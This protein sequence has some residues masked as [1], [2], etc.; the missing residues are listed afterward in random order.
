LFTVMFG[1]AAAAS[2][3]A[4]LAAAAIGSAP[5]GTKPATPGNTPLPPAGMNI[6]PPPPPPAE[7]QRG[8]ALGLFAEDVS[9]SYNALLAEVV[10]LG[11][12]H[13]ALVVP[14]YQ[15]HGGSHD[16]ALHTRYSPTLAA[17]AEIIRAARRDDLAVM[18]FPIVRLADPRPG[19]WRGT[20]APKDRDAW[21]RRYGEVLGELAA[22]GGSTGAKR[23]VIGSELS[24][25]DEKDEDVE[26][27]RRLIERVRSVFDG[28]LVYSANWDHYQTTRLYDLVDEE[29]ISGYFNLREATGAADD[30][31][32][33][34]G[35]RRVRRDI[36]S[37]RGGRTRPFV[38]TELGY[39]SR[40]GASA[41]PW[42]ESP[43]GRADPG[44]QR[45]AFAAFRKVWTGASNL[46]GVY[47]WNWYG[48]GG[49]GTIGYSPRGK[50]AEIEIRALLQGL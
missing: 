46:D 5:P 36:E 29:G 48:Y 44:E 26:R 18:L 19:E 34:S 27:W 25:L 9:F 37:W 30:D 43:G 13:V 49:S 41:S 45:R 47:I 15:T 21:F 7:R 2:V 6:P 8:V 50:P 24:S 31:A 20:L 42:D 11:A 1:R 35:W 40:S 10:A 4:V 32:L 12:T 3:A 16:L 17:L 28:K 23:L 14:L 22:V 38:F 33:E 39:R